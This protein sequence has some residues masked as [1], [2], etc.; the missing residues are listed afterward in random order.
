MAPF[1]LRLASFHSHGAVSSRMEYIRQL[2]IDHD[3]ILIQ[4][5]W[6]HSSKIHIYEDEI[7]DMRAHGISAVKDNCN[8]LGIGQRRPY[9]DRP[10]SVD[11]A[12]T[13]NNKH[14]PVM[15]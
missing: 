12:H 5:H 7:A 11:Q 15:V 10:A 6:L 8:E 4:E 9:S 3:I 1:A 14:T 13:K 2:A